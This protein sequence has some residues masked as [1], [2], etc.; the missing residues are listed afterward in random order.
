[1]GSQV[2]RH[3]FKK[4]VEEK[5]LYWKAHGKKFSTADLCD[6]FV[7]YFESGERITVEVYGM[8]KRGTVSVTSGWKPTFL[9]MLRRTS[10]WSSWLLKDDVPILRSSRITDPVQQ[11]VAAVKEG[12]AGK[13]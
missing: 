12:R 1:V 8:V 5:R 7:P 10:R 2:E 11:L 4:Y 13:L 9:L 3:D 6:K